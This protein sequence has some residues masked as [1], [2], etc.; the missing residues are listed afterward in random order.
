MWVDRYRDSGKT[1]GA[2]IEEVFHMREAMW[3]YGE[4]STPIKALPPPKHVPPPPQP[5]KRPDDNQG[6]GKGGG[7]Q[8]GGGKKIKAIKYYLKDNTKL[9]PDW[10][11]GSCKNNMYNCS[12]GKHMCGAVEV[13][14]R[15]CGGRHTPSRCTNKRV[16]RA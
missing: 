2:V 13:G 1:L 7:G 10:Q 5:P 11:K 3:E 14:G 9:C 12:K 15:V 16:E 6:G 8:G 4:S